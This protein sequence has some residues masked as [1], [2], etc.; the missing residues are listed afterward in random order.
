MRGI[1]LKVFVKEHKE[2]SWEHLE[3]ILEVDLVKS[4]ESPATSLR[5]KS[6]GSF[7]GRKLNHI[8][9]EK[10]DQCVF[11]GRTDFSSSCIDEKGSITE[12]EA[13]DKGGL[14]LDNQAQPS[15]VWGANLTT[16]FTRHIASYGYGLVAGESGG[17]LPEFTVYQGRSQWQVF[18][19]FSRRL[20]GIKPYVVGDM[21][22]CSLPQPSEDTL[23]FC[24][25]T[26]KPFTSLKQQYLPYEIISKVYLRDSEGAYSSGVTSSEAVSLDITRQRYLTPWD[27]N[28]KSARDNANQIINDSLNS[29]QVFFI[30][31]PQFF[32]PQ[33]GTGVS[34]NYESFQEKGLVL[35][36][37]KTGF[38][39]QGEY[40][41]LECRRPIYRR[42][43]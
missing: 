26:A 10:N 37:L 30:E 38:N 20:L 29:S 13:R 23:V 22:Y 1:S 17:W 25:K 18:C 24:N 33:V 9:L 27:E 31:S 36:Q 7:F 19:D 32:A 40:S 15:T 41:I 16:M 5:V 2:D 8:K 14:L 11:T 21:V 42:I 3:N 28:T 43:I 12:I 39:S 6:A 34:V 4:I 35:W